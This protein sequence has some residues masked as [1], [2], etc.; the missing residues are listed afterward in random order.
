MLLTL[1]TMSL[2]A[3]PAWR[4]WHTG[5]DF[6]VHHADQE[7]SYRAPERRVLRDVAHTPVRPQW[8][9]RHLRGKDAQGMRRLPQASQDVPFLHCLE[10]FQTEE[11]VTDTLAAD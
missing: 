4:S 8:L 2:G 9:H 1:M 10:L 3:M 7:K 6:V 5:A 11:T